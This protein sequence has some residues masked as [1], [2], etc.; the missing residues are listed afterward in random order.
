MKA[1][2]HKRIVS[3]RNLTK[4]EV[5]QGKDFNALLGDYRKITKPFYKNRRLMRAVI[6]IF[7]I[8]L[9][10]MIVVIEERSR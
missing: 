9:V 2:R 7:I 10:L 4:S 8:L 5:E 3:R 6:L 1:K